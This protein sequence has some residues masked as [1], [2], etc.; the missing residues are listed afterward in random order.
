MVALE[1]LK[2]SILIIRSDIEGMRDG[3]LE[4]REKVL[5]SFEDIT[6]MSERVKSDLSFFNVKRD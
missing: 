6:I 3:A 4:I 1:A 2:S 5:A